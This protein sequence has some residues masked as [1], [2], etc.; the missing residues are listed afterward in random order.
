MVISAETAPPPPLERHESSAVNGS[1]LLRDALRSDL[2]GFNFPA[3][4]AWGK[5]KI[6]RCQNVK[7][8]GEMI[9]G[10]RRSGV[11]WGSVSSAMRLGPD[12]GCR[13]VGDDVVL[14]D[15]RTKLLFH[16]REAAERIKV[17][18]PF[19][20]QQNSHPE[21]PLETKPHI[22][23]GSSESSL[24]SQAAEPSDSNRPWNLRTRRVPIYGDSCSS[25]S[26]PATQVPAAAERSG[27][28]RNFRLRSEAFDKRDWPKI[29]IP[30]TRE[31]IE[32]DVYAVTGLRPRR[33]PKKRPRILQRQL[34]LLLPGSW[35]SSISP[36]SYRVPE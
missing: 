31:E 25:P 9:A 5:H 8:K 19:P 33:R 6:L 17:A 7:R 14:E 10:A 22:A 27:Q 24:R 2:D 4:K 29:S 34:D 23:L 20:N 28:T 36:D 13:G 12:E 26:P 32:E 35:L 18:I 11:L 1:P 30:L 3:L 21:Q 15:V 16:L